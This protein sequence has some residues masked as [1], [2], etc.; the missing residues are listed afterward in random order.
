MVDTVSINNDEII[1]QCGHKIVAKY[2]IND[3]NLEDYDFLVIPGGKAVMEVLVNDE[4][5]SKL[6][7]YFNDQNKL[8]CAICAAPYLI[9]KLGLFN[10]VNYTCFPGFETKIQSGNHKNK[11]VI[12][13]KNFITG[14][15]MFY[16]IE[17]GLKIVEELLGKEKAKEVKRS[18]MGIK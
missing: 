1:T 3:I 11:G 16:S 5:V 9:G 17:F 2:S 10:G 14:K 7:N 18:M 12:K 6:I 13:D 4:K 15:S 8:I